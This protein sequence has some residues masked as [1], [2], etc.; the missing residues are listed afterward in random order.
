MVVAEVGSV[1]ETGIAAAGFEIVELEVA[2]ADIDI[3]AVE[4]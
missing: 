2:V 1:A 4:V 3:A